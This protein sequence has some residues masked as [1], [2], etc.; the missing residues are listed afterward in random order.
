MAICAYTGQK[1]RR[2]PIKAYGIRKS[3]HGIHAA[4]SILLAMFSRSLIV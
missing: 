2:N 4:V 3:A 1:N